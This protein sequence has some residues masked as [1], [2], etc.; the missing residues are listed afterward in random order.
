MKANPASFRDPAGRVFEA[1]GEVYRAIYEAGMEDFRSANRDGIYDILIKKNLLIDHQEVAPET[2]GESS[3][4]ICL[5]HPRVPMVSY[6]WEWPFSILRDAALLHLRIMEILVPRGYWL[7]DANAFNVQFDG[8]RLKL[9]DTLSIGRREEGRPWVAYKQFCSQ[10]LAPLAVAAKSDIR[11]FDLWRSNL[12]G[13][14][15][16]LAVK[17]LPGSARLNPRL[18]M[19]LYLHARMQ[20][21]SDSKDQLHQTSPKEVRMSDTALLGLVRSLRKAVAGLSYKPSSAI[22]QGYTE[23]RTYDEADVKTK[24]RFIEQAIERLQ[25]SVV[26]DF[27]GNTGEFSEIAA[28]GGAFVVSVDSDPA[29]TEY[30]YQRVSS[31]EAASGILPLTMD[32]ANPSPALGFNQEERQGLRERGPADLLLGLA[33]IHHLV[34]SSSVPLERVAQWFGQLSR[35]LLIEFVPETDPM[36]RKLL[37]NRGDD[38]LPYS[39][40]VFRSAF[41]AEFEVEQEQALGNGRRLFVLKNKTEL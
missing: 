41:E 27:G 28:R 38:H 33:L 36:V 37:V 7:R 30:L 1:D 9:I 4:V 16:D 21:S 17:L 32:L 5:R 18:Y 2:L 11:L 31:G 8:E 19:H 40:E 25:P 39:L 3:N 14:P 34:F 24:T 35:R 15:L 10:F 6:P 22:W 29:C 12:E 20:V 26:W 13:F 23:I